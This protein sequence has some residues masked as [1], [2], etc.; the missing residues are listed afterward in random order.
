MAQL[1]VATEI[2]L[3]SVVWKFFEGVWKSTNTCKNG[4]PQNFMHLISDES[5]RNRKSATPPHPLC[6]TVWKYMNIWALTYSNH[7][8]IYCYLWAFAGIRIYLLFPKC[9]CFMCTNEVPTIVHATQE[10]RKSDYKLYVRKSEDLI[11]NWSCFVFFF[12]FF[13]IH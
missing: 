3:F 1:L 9:L 10:H 6:I 12:S 2:L 5:Y 7:T 8:F 4:H 13:F 11:S